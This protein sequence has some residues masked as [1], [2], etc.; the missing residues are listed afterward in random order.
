MEIVSRR[1]WDRFWSKVAVGEAADCW[2]WTA[3]TFRERNGYGKF[4]AGGRRGVVYAHRFGWEL[5]R[6]PIPKGMHVCHHCDNPP[7]V[8]PGHLFAGTRSDNLS[9]AARKGRIAGP[10]GHMGQ[11]K[12]CGTLQGYSAHRRAGTPVCGPCA[13]AHNAY[14]RAWRERRANR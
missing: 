4:Q 9:D 14:N 11:P 8:N 10:Y 13:K 2:P 1:T 6:G 5:L 3:S 7:C 12:P